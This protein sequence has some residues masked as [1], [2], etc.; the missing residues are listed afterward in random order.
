MAEPA[1]SAAA[2][3]G[4]PAGPSAAAELRRLERRIRRQLD[5]RQA[6]RRVWESVPAIV[7]ILAAVAAAY[8]I[9]HWGLGHAIPLLAVTVT[10]TS[11]GFARDARPIRVAETVVG[12]LLGIALGDALA[13]LFGQGLW[14]LLVVLAVVLVVGRAVSA[15]PAFAVAAAVPSALVVLLPVPDG[16]PFG[17]SLDGLVG[18][19]VALLATALIPRDPR[20]AAA[21]DGRTLFSV[22]DESLG[23]IVDC[24]HDADPAAGELALT[25]LRRTQP[26]VDAWATSLDT[27]I[28]I[29][30]ISPWVHRYLAELR[31]AARVQSAA[32]LTARHLRTIARRAEYLVRDG[33]RRPA[34]AGVFSELATGIRL[35]GQELDDPQLTGAARSLLTD[36]ARRL[37]PKV[38]MPDAG[39]ADAAL[40]LLVRPLVVDLLVGTGLPVADARAL[41]PRV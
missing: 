21:R 41:L 40:L 37:D 25:R 34:L 11:L 18:G 1:A 15:S 14:Q 35:L 33:T 38:V 7:Q 13:L 16:G 17:R 27:A 24:L 12:I 22:F 23:S 10:I 31:R 30:R 26:L 4:P 6:G 2:S 28:S 36:L 20:K 8:A 3:P 9:A 32:D 39:V 19:V 5:V 29:A